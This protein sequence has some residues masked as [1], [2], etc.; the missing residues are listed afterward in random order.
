MS[1]LQ[2]HALWLAA[3][4]AGSALASAWIARR[5]SWQDVR[6]RQ[7]E[8]A[9]QA[10]ARY[11]EWVAAQRRAIAFAGDRPRGDSALVQL[12]Q[13]QQ[14]GFPEL[15]PAMIGLLEAHAR[16]LDFLWAQ[17]QLRAADPE[18]WLESDHDGGFLALWSEL[19]VAMRRLAGPLRASA[20]ELASDAEPESVFPV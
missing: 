5:V 7:A 11:G 19:C 10:L 6:Q 3:V 12:R 2:Y 1:T 9:L 20:G 17:Q 15:A 4:I 18:A 16:M 8:Q 14:A 13:W